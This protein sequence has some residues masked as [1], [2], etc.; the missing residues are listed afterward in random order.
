[1]KTF[2]IFFMLIFWMILTVILTLS[3]IGMMAFMF[4]DNYSES[5]WFI[6]GK[7]MF[8]YILK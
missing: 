3:I 7:Q 6:F 8:D 2:I 4:E 5:Y 1:M